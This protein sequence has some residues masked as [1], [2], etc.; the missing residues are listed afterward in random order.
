MRG[1]EGPKSAGGE[2]KEMKEEIQ[3]VIASVEDFFGCFFDGDGGGGG[4]QQRMSRISRVDA[5]RWVRRALLKRRSIL[6]EHEQQ[7][8][9]WRSFYRGLDDANLTTSPDPCATAATASRAGN[10]DGE[11]IGSDEVID[12]NLFAL[13]PGWRLQQRLSVKDFISEWL[14]AFLKVPLTSNGSQ[15]ISLHALLSTLLALLSTAY[16]LF[17]VQ[18]T[19]FSQY[20]QVISLPALLSTLLS[21][22]AQIKAQILTPEELRASGYG[23]SVRS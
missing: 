6:D 16:M 13:F 8:E 12:M 18:R 10:V 2:K 1:L 17:S 15:V 20:S 14:V 7:Q 4:E 5:C 22:K 23:P 11:G 9:S 21:T 19:C 3:A